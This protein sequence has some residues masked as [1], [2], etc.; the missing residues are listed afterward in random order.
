M[1]SRGFGTAEQQAKKINLFNEAQEQ[2]Q[3]SEEV[4]QE[5]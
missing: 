1:I 5:Q 4:I 3:G 2:I